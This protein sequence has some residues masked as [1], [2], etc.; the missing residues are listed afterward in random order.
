MKPIKTLYAQWT[1][2]LNAYKLFVLKP[3]STGFTFE[4]I[5]GY[6]TDLDEAEFEYV[7]D[8]DAEYSKLVLCDPDVYPEYDEF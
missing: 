8:E 4:D 7:I 2:F 1:P 3:G 6:V 5:I